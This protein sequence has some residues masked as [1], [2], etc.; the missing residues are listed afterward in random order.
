MD[1]A[2]HTL[3]IEETF[4]ALETGRRGLSPAEVERRLEEYGPNEIE[5]AE[6]VSKLEILWAQI[7]NPLVFV[8]V[9]STVFVADEIRKLVSPQTD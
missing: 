2:W 4:D 5:R 8:L 3:E 1:R 6:E 9:S 7:K